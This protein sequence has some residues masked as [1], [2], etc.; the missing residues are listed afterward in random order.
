MAKKTRGPKK[1][2]EQMADPNDVMKMPS[3]STVKSIAASIRA[4]K[5]STGKINGDLSDEIAEAKKEKG[6]HPGS[7][8]RVEALL[9]KAK[10]TDRGLAA[11]AAELAHFDYYRDVLGLT[12]M[13]DEQG[14][15]FARTEAGEEDESKP[16]ARSTTE[17]AGEAAVH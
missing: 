10:K 3:E 7:L 17:A 11:V 9:A 13:L 5:K 8:K 15:M 12:K 4:A 16:E 14:Q 2:V 6:I 1:K